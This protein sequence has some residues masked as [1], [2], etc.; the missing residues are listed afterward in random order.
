MSP[1]KTKTVSYVL[2]LKSNP[3]QKY[4]VLKEAIVSETQGDSL[5]IYVMV[6]YY[7]N[8]KNNNSGEIVSCFTRI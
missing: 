4:A 5:E 6:S 8:F 7:Q 1:M 3:K 2:G